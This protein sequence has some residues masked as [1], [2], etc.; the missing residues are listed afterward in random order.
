MLDLVA[1]EMILV[2]M[3]FKTT[4]LNF[5]YEWL[6]LVGMYWIQNKISDLESK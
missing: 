1:I 2:D 3:N 5:E 6:L 4:I